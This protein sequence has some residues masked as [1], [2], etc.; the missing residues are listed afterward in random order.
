MRVYGFKLSKMNYQ[1]KEVGN[2][3]GSNM[4]NMLSLKSHT[5]GFNPEDQPCP[6]M[7][8]SA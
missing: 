6:P 5:L 7:C 2:R 4:I 8:V 1:N 3:G